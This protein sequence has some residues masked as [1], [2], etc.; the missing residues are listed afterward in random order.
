MEDYKIFEEYAIRKVRVIE[1]KEKKNI[2]LF[3]Y[4]TEAQSTE[5]R[6]INV[7]RQAFSCY[8]E[9]YASGLFL[10][11]SGLD[12]P[13][14]E[15]FLIRDICNSLTELDHIS[16]RFCSDIGFEILDSKG[17]IRTFVC[18]LA[19]IENDNSFCFKVREILKQKEND[20]IKLLKHMLGIT[21]DDRNYVE[22]FMKTLKLNDI[23][24]Q[25]G[26][27]YDER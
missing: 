17:N 16:F 3:P 12:N 24:I 13:E 27:F 11:R 7:Y 8:C 18:E 15:K 1:K 22:S 14:K 4:I 19:P 20:V 2:R 5:T 9:I 6:F 23:E 26:K 25:K 10:F 21:K